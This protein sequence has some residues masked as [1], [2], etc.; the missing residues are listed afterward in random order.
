[1]PSKATT[2]SSD[3]HNPAAPLFVVHDTLTNTWYE[4]DAETWHDLVLQ[5]SDPD[6]EFAYACP[7]C[8][9]PLMYCSCPMEER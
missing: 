6:D 1:M 5:G 8:L 2:M 7:G 9:R 3:S 4:L